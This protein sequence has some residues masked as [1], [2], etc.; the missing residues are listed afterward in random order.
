MLCHSLLQWTTFCQNSPPRPVRLGWPYT[1]WL[2]VSLHSSFCLCS[3]RGYFPV[4]CKFWR[5]C[6]GV[7]GDLFQEGSWHTQVCCSQSP[8]LCSRPLLTWT[9]AGDAQTQFWL[10]VWWVW[11]LIPNAISPLLLSCWGFSFAL[12]CG[13]SFSGGIQPSPVDGCSAASCNFGVLAGAVST[14]PS[15][16]P[17]WS[18]PCRS[19]RLGQFFNLMPNCSPT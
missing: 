18:L 14:C 8:R 13:V 3:P 11:A 5:L 10:G 19:G 16:P 6:G 7:N 1:A 9:S 12:G 17:S 15:T 2:I 4:L